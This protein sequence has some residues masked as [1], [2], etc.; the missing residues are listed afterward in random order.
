MTKTANKPFKPKV[1]NCVYVDYEKRFAIGSDNY[2][3]IVQKGKNRYF[4]GTIESLFLTFL[5][6]EMH[7]ISS[8]DTKAVLEALHH[9]EN[10]IKTICEGIKR[11][12]K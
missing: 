5:E 3:W 11:K 4:Y 1:E 9:V 7:H 2:Q 8:L 6:R 10:D 12:T